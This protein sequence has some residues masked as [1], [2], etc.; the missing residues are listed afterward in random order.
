MKSY[1]S[2]LGKKQSVEK[3][4]R[5]TANGASELE[6]LLTDEYRALTKIGNDFRIRHH[7]TN[8][9]DIADSRHYDYFFNRC[10]SLIA[11]SIQYLE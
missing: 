9:I 11:L 10:L 4:V 2:S 3:V 5:D 1:Y 6:K 7:E 8:T